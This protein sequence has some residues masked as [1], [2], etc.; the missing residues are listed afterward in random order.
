MLRIGFAALAALA[1]G[2]SG[3]EAR[4][5]TYTISG[6]FNSRFSAG[7]YSA[8]LSSAFG[9]PQTFEAVFRVDTESADLNSQVGQ[10]SYR[11]LPASVKVDGVEVLSGTTNLH[12]RPGMNRPELQYLT[13]VAGATKD[14]VQESPGDE[15]L[16][17]GMEF[18]FP[19][20]S[21]DLESMPTDSALFDD[22]VLFQ[23]S[24]TLSHAGQWAFQNSAATAIS[25]GL[26]GLTASVSV[27]PVPE[28]GEWA[29][30]GAGLAVVG[31]VGR[32]R[33]RG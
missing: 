21:F 30:M 15:Q 7:P 8:A 2:A 13:F 27:A 26:T 6:F 17:L 16:V 10:T 29:M 32:R 1:I 3:A 31:F 25:N 23:A 22:V 24:Y 20:G 18:S 33:R 9:T 28:P 5:V 12:L 14:Y 11:G 4:T 19:A